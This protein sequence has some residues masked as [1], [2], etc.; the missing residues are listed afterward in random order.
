MLRKLIKHEW[1]ATWRNLALFNGGIILLGILGRIMIPL[2]QN[3]R[4]TEIPLFAAASVICIFFYIFAIFAVAIVTNVLLI[5]R[6]Y[7]NMFTDEGYLMHTLPV[8]PASHIISKLLVYMAWFVINGFSLVA[9]IS[10]LV[11]ENIHWGRFFKSLWELIQAMGEALSTPA[12][13]VA[14]YLLLTA[15]AVMASLV[16]C[17]YFSASVGN[18][19]NTHKKLGAVL[20][21]VGLN[22][23]IQFLQA[24]A[25]IF[26]QWNS[27][28]YTV[29]TTEVAGGTVSYVTQI[30]AWPILLAALFFYLLLDTVFFLGT[31]RILSRQLNLE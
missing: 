22:M 13:L 16:L 8:S 4:L 10:I 28:T 5:A 1:K 11:S 14:F 26:F 15:L 27:L 31:Q 24:M 17:I 19:F 30:N 2:V 29:E 18:L 20:C 6:F 7:R 9:S 25:L 3:S 23:A 12:V 21:F